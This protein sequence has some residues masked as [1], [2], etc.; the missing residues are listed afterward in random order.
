MIEFEDACHIIEYDDD[1]SNLVARAKKNRHKGFDYYYEFI[2]PEITRLVGK[3][4]SRKELNS[5]KYYTMIRRYIE[6]IFQDG[7]Q[8]T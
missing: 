4:S 5:G 7:R 2:K 1:V 3:N 8:R 6:D